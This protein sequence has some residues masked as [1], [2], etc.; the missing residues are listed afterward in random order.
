MS[1]ATTEPGSE[2]TQTY[3]SKPDGALKTAS[4]FALPT[5]YHTSW[6]E[7]YMDGPHYRIDVEGEPPYGCDL[8]VFHGTHVPVQGGWRKSVSVQAFQAT[9]TFFLQTVL[10]GK[11]EASDEVQKGLWVVTNPNGERYAMPTKEFE[12]RYELPG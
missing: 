10:D 9:G 3:R 8:Q 12:A 1:S 7:Q 5:T 6:G 2:N 11:V 4:Y